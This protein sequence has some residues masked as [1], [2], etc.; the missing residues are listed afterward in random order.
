MRAPW[1]WRRH[2]PAPSEDARAAVQQADRALRDAHR[3]AEHINEVSFRADAVARRADEV[4]ARNHFA[5]AI[6]DSI[7]RRVRHT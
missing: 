3:L 7:R 5:E 2:P 1:A 4:R 6:E